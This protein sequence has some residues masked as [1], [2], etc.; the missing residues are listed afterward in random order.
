M[1]SRCP[2]VDR[3]EV[4]L[5]PVINPE[6]IHQVL[7]QDGYLSSSGYQSDG[8]GSSSTSGNGMSISYSQAKTIQDA[9]SEF[10]VDPGEPFTD[11]LFSS[12]RRRKN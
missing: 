3:D 10:V 6:A 12:K 8:Q 4:F 9:I 2:D 5:T 11:H 7:E 1:T